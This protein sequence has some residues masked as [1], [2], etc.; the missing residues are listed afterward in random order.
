M[1]TR[2]Q[3][4][5]KSWTGFRSKTLWTHVPAFPEPP[6]LLTV[7]PHGNKT[8]AISLLS[9]DGGLRWGNRTGSAWSGHSPGPDRAAIA[10][11]RRQ[12]CANATA[13][14]SGGCGAGRPDNRPAS[15][16]A[17]RQTGP[18]RWRIV[19]AGR[20][21]SRN[22]RADAG[23]RQ[24]AGDSAPWQPRRR[25]RDPAEIGTFCRD[26]S[27]DAGLLDRSLT[28]SLYAARSRMRHIEP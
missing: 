28:H 23:R 16:A 22:A 27:G 9:I 12:L 7:S 15:R 5:I 13:G 18:V 2:H 19:P 26:L 14:P 17:R 1:R 24:Y 25:P 3:P 21:R 6:R 8:L 20:R 10:L 11:A 4:R